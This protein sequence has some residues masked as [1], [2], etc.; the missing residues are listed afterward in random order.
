M[1]NADKSKGTAQNL[2]GK[3][4]AAFGQLVGDEEQESKGLTREAF[5]QVQQA[6]GTAVEEVS[7]FVN[8][9]PMAAVAIVAG[10]S[11][12]AGLFIRRK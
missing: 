5:G 4:Q 3:A 10:I 2:A 8:R 1:I 6:Y 9:R 11:I 7:D 12:I